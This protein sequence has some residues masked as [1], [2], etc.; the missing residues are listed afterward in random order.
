M[1]TLV[2]IV[3]DDSS[4]R[5]RRGQTPE[6]EA[7]VLDADLE[8]EPDPEAKAV[9]FTVPGVGSLFDGKYRILRKIG[10]GG[11]GVVMLA[12][13]EDLAR[14]V[15]LKLIRPDCVGD[16]RA[17]NLFLDEAR[18]M[19]RIRHH[20]VVEIHAFAECAG[21]PYFVMEYVDGCDL[22]DWLMRH[23]GGMVTI[24]E[25]IGVLSQICQGVEALHASG[26]IHQ[27]LKP[28]NVL[29]GPQF[30]VAVTD[31]GLARVAAGQSKLPIGTPPFSAPE[32]VRGEHIDPKLAP[33][34]DVYAL[35]AIAYQLLTGCY[36]FPIED[37]QK[38]F[39]YQ[40][41]YDPVPPSTVRPELPPAFDDVVLAALARNPLERMPSAKAFRQALLGA[42]E[43]TQTRAIVHP[44]IVLA[45][46]DPRFLRWLVRV[47][48]QIAP[49]SELL[50]AE[51]GNQALVLTRRRRPA[52]VISDLQMPEMN[53]IELT[54]A[55]RGDPLTR[56]VPIVITTAVGGAPEWRTLDQ[57][58]A[59]GYLVKP[60]SA[61]V[62]EGTIGRFLKARQRALR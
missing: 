60:F 43:V 41:E 32:V 42:R 48:E 57:L 4:T 6:D 24:D 34:V 28:A 17:R 55:L 54:A 22:F 12:Q 33:R 13:D 30:R 59:N 29:V 19:A 61:E 53:G 31:F 51:D 40:S 36:A 46:D 38:L 20:N 10:Q 26:T 25:A 21:I 58:G 18:A 14:N 45:D 47:L 3:R 23:E 15:A 27:D 37:T 7:P 50:L 1:E 49:M 9:P 8:I 39:H 2:P 62:L 35:G 44:S 52:L 56:D 5:R 16:A 11:M